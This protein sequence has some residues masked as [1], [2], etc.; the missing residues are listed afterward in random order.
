MTLAMFPY[1]VWQAGTNQNSI[2]ANDN[3][4]RSE[5]TAKAALGVANAAP[6][7][8]VDGAVYLVG[9]AWG[10]FATDDVVLFRSGTWYGFAPFDGWIKYRTDTETLYVYDGGWQEYAGG[11]GEADRNAV[12]ALSIASGSVAV[13][14][15]A[16]DF[17][18][19]ALSASVTGFTFN[20]LP[21]AGKGASIMVQ[22]TQ[23]STPR[24]V[25][26]PSSFRWAGGAAGTV[27]A[28]ASAVDL[29]ALTTFDNGTTW[30]ATLSKGRA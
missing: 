2:P 6:G 5:I 27:S 15:A 14:V 16:G 18:T 1:A 25:V 9:T 8:P 21:G 22:I 30:Q 24:T 17:F 23:G 26:W 13:N 4:L 29:L 7:S 28:A 12:T 10:A 11:G 20:G 3:S 19:L